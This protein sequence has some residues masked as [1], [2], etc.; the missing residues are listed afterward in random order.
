MLT[1]LTELNCKSRELIR[2]IYL[3][4]RR[5]FRLNFINYWMYIPAEAHGGPSQAS[6]VDLFARIANGFKLDFLFSRKDSL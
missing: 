3:L 1:I 6:K 5:Y 2:V 4:Q